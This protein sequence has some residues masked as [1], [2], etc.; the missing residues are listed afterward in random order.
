MRIS[1]L[2]I[3]SLTLAV[4]V[5]AGAHSR[6]AQARVP[7][8]PPMDSHSQPA[9]TEFATFYADDFEGRP[10]ADGRVF[11]MRDPRVAAS[12]RWPLGTRLRL[13]RAAGGPWE[14]T[15]SPAE[16][17]SY[18]AHSIIV[19]VEDRGDFDHALDLSAAAFAQLG[20]PDEGIIPVSIEQLS[21]PF[22]PAT[23]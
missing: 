13:R 17:R 8:G 10:M 11:D 5:A 19:T 14:A 16:L 18:L 6:P 7:A 22:N 20:R 15:L 1:A 9:Q 4:V 23:C 12:N 2:L 3:L 21:Y